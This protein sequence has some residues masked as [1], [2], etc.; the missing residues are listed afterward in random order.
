MKRVILT[1]GTPGVGK[2]TYCHKVVERHPEVAYLSRDDLAYEL[3]GKVGFN[4]YV[5]ECA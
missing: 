5:G 2:S 4:P 1:I 3:L